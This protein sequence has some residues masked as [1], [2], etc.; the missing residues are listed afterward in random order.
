MTN[1]AV[2]L[3]EAAAQYPHRPAMRLDQEVLTYADLD[4]LSSRVAGGLVAHGVRPG[5]RVGIVLEHELAFPVLYYGIL[6]VGA[7]VVPLG[8][9]LGAHEAR[10]C[11]GDWGV[12]LVFTSGTGAG[13]LHAAEARSA[14]RVCVAVGPGFLDQLAF[15]PRRPDLVRRADDD[16]AAVAWTRATT[17]SLVLPRGHEL[18]HGALRAGAYDAATRVLE[19]TSSDVVLSSLPMSAS[20]SQMC[21]LNAAVLAGACLTQVREVDTAAFDAVTVRAV[22]RRSA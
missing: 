9:R 1:L 7:V 16:L 6:R 19:L 14:G 17:Q 20:P 22:T 13:A 3:K 15:W 8:P 18:T 2:N 11:F 21:G 5:D 4:E 10:R 12:R